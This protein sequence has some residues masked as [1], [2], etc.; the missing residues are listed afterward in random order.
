MQKGQKRENVWV[1]YFSN[2]FK[3]KRPSSEVK[4]MKLNSYKWSVSHQEALESYFVTIDT[5]DDFSG[6]NIVS[7]N[8]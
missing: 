8:R 4:I 5:S 7:F 6:R 3:Y 2:F 1:I